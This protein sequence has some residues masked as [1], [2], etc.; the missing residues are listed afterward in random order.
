MADDF[1]AKVSFRGTKDVYGVDPK[2]L[3]KMSYRDAML[4][5][6]IHANKKYISACTRFFKLPLDKTHYR[7]SVELNEEMKKYRKSL[8]LASLKLREIGISSSMIVVSPEGLV[9][10]V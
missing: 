3:A 2:E 1:G 7:E 4:L 6:Y 8:E 9:S 10:D 5:M